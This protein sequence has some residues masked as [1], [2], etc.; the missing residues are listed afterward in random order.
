MSSRRLMLRA[1]GAAAAALRH[2]APVAAY[3]EEDY[4][5]DPA[6]ITGAVLPAFSQRDVF[7]HIH[8]RGGPDRED[9]DLKARILAQDKAAG[10]DRFVHV[11]VWREWLEAASTERISYTGQAIGRQLGEALAARG[12]LRSLHVCGTSAGAFAANEVIS[13]YVG[14]AGA[15]RAATWLTL[16]DPFCA[17]ADEGVCMPRVICTRT[18]QARHTAGVA[19][20]AAHSKRRNAHGIALSSYPQSQ[21]SPPPWLQA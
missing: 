8:G 14:A 12:G 9:A 15:S 3:T 16:C 1:G 11:F 6:D 13:A 19:Q 4:E 10:L 2:P 18:H 20:Q 5:R 7:L 21:P 17:R